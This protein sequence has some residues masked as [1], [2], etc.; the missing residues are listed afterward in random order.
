MLENVSTATSSQKT[1][2]KILMDS[3][4]LA[5]APVEQISVY[6]RFNAKQWNA[7]T[8]GISRHRKFGVWNTKSFFNMQV[9]EQLRHFTRIAYVIIVPPE[10]CI[11]TAAE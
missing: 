11:S 5:S 6:L 10:R 4:K 8:S 9:L 3:F 2:N 7:E 1:G